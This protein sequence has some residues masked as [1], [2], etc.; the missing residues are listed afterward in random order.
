MEQQRTPQEFIQVEA[1]NIQWAVFDTDQLS[2]IRGS[3][4]LLAQAIRALGSAFS[5][6][7]DPLSIGASRGLYE[8]ISDRPL[9]ELVDRI[10]KAINDDPNHRHFTFAVA[11][12]Q[13]PDDEDKRGLPAVKAALTARIRREQLR[14][15]SLVPDIIEGTA[16]VPCDQS[17]VRSRDAAGPREWIGGERKAL[18]ASVRDRLRIGRDLK[19][20]LYFEVLESAQTGSDETESAQPIGP[21][22][23]LARAG[24]ETTARHRR[25][26]DR[27]GV[28]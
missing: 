27:R 8:V 2:V 10:Q 24:A 28:R 26:H 22:G 3:S 20:G 14:Q 7:L 16:Q 9:P 4:F 12:H 17:G 23:T 25:S 1:V 19:A 15:L 21:P 5:D 6:D 18:S 13:Q 11:G